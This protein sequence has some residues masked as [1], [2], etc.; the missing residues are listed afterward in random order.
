MTAEFRIPFAPP[1]MIFVSAF[2]VG[3][4]IDLLYPAPILPLLLQL[5]IGGVLVAFGGLL[6]RSSMTHMRRGGTTYNPFA[7]S[8]ALVTS[9]IYAT[10]RNPGYL[11]LAVVQLGLAVAIDSPW[12]VGTAC[13]AVFVVDRFVVA[14]EERKLSN[15]F[16]DEYHAYC[17]R[18]RRW[19]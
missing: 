14:L 13:I 17:T 9:G 8:T 7:A 15:A 4:A 18:V 5:A 3:L 19:L 16:G 6:I 2:I 11:G 12:I 1:P 10:T